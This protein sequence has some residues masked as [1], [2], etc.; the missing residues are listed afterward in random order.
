MPKCPVEWG[1]GGAGPNEECLKDG[2]QYWDIKQLRCAYVPK[3]A[4]VSWLTTKIE[5]IETWKCTDGKVF[6]DPQ[7]A[8]DHQ[9]RLNVYNWVKCHIRFQDI[10]ADDSNC[11]LIAQ[12]LVDNSEELAVLLGWAEED[13][14]A[15]PVPTGYSPPAEELVVSC[16]G[17]IP[18]GYV[19]DVIIESGNC[20]RGF[21]V[22]G[23]G[24]LHKLR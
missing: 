5:K 11:K 15:M 1:L 18:R 17:D 4:T 6:D 20:R 14:L 21:F 8:E 3:E 9:L 16:K 10:M 22:S 12:L 24:T 23:D 19:D 7:K 13:D 2:C